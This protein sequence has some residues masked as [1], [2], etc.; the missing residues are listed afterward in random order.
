MEGQ[1]SSILPLGL[2]P[3]ARGSA[4]Q[5][6]SRPAWRRGGG[7]SSRVLPTWA[8]ACGGELK[9]VLTNGSMWE[10]GQARD[11]EQVDAHPLIGVRTLK[12]HFSSA[13]VPPRGLGCCESRE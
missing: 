8:L 5:G 2:S 1:V 9:V 4:R 12:G 13:R 7:P 11:P 6:G 3:V 10:A